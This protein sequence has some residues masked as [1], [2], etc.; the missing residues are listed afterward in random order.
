MHAL[1]VAAKFESEH[2][3]GQELAEMTTLEDLE[4]YQVGH[5]PNASPDPDPDP[6]PEPDPDP[7]LT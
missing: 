6:D 1:T 2:V 5:K 4:D 3:D 7:D